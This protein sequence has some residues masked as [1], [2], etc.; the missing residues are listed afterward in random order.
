M[1]MTDHFRYSTLLDPSAEYD[2]DLYS[3]IYM[4]LFHYFFFLDFAKLIADPPVLTEI[5][6]TPQKGINHQE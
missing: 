6:E 3:T 4:E 1:Y 2:M 5:Q